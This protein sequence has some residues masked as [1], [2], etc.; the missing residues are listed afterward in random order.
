MIQVALQRLA[1]HQS[2]PRSTWKTK[3]DLYAEQDENSSENECPAFSGRLIIS[4]F[5]REQKSTYSF[6]K[7]INTIHINLPIDR[8]GL[9]QNK[10]SWVSEG[11]INKS[12]SITDLRT[13][14]SLS[15]SKSPRTR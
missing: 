10:I 3:Y 15:A 12:W 14:E 11:V 6:S 7:T 13:D 4:L 9:H 5:C 2:A 1:E 8:D